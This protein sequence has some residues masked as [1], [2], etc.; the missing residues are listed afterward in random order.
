M[1]LTIAKKMSA[2]LDIASDNIE[3]DIIKFDNYRVTFLSRFIQLYPSYIE[4]ANEESLCQDRIMNTLNKLDNKLDEE[5]QKIN[6]GEKR[7]EVLSKLNSVKEIA[8]SRIKESTLDIKEEQ[9][10]LYQIALNEITRFWE[11]LPEG[12]D[13]LSDNITYIEIMQDTLRKGI[14][15]LNTKE[16]ASEIFKDPISVFNKYGSNLLKQIAGT[17]PEYIRNNKGIP[18]VREEIE[19]NLEKNIESLKKSNFL[20]DDGSISEKTKELI[21]FKAEAQNHYLI[22]NGYFQASKNEFSR[23]SKVLREDKKQSQ[24]RFLNLT[25]NSKK[26]HY[27]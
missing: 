13:T 18:G 23:Y 21:T 16:I 12:I 10:V 2:I 8:S 22:S 6:C 25:R 3:Q 24:K 1:S 15:T 4:L 7:R 19:E 20:N 11:S 14:T 26:Q 17:Y 5:I 9:K 27:R